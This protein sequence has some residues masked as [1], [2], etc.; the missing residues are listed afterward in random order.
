MNQLNW[1]LIIISF[2]TKIT[3]LAGFEKIFRH[4]YICFCFPFVSTIG[5]SVLKQ[6]VPR[7]LF[8]ILLRYFSFSNLIARC[9]VIESFFFYW[10]VVPLYHFCYSRLLMKSKIKRL[11]ANCFKLS[12]FVNNVY[13]SFNMM[14]CSLGKSPA[15]DQKAR[16]RITVYSLII[17]LNKIDD[18]IPIR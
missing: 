17:T 15:V 3:M 12:N 10:S 9:F 11:L 2:S 16:L 1:I 13:H 18:I 7:S 5:N 4:L 6:R 8:F 14:E